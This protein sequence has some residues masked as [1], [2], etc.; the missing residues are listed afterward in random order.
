M[1]YYII[2][3]LLLWVAFLG[4]GGGYSCAVARRCVP[5]RGGSACVRACVRAACVLS[6][7]PCLCT[8]TTSDAAAEFSSA[9]SAVNSSSVAARTVR[10]YTFLIH[11]P[12]PL[13]PSHA[14]A[15]GR[16]SYADIV[17][18]NGFLSSL[19]WNALGQRHHVVH[20]RSRLHPDMH[21]R[22]Q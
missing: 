14:H 13:L 22:R 17:R 1:R 6:R 11:T 16:S 12:P 20:H 21:N 9:A 2:I 15:A 8:R 3:L 19:L 5:R 10:V 7:T 4:G 18:T